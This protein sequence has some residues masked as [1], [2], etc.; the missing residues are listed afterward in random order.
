MEKVAFLNLT[1]N[2]FYHNRIWEEFFNQGDLE[3]KLEMP[4]SATCDR[5]S[6]VVA[7]AQ[8]FFIDLVVRPALK[9]F[10]RLEN[11]CE[12]KCMKNLDVCQDSWYAVAKATRDNGTAAATTGNG[13]SKQSAKKQSSGSSMSN[14]DDED[15]SAECNGGGD[16]GKQRTYMSPTSA[17]LLERATGATSKLSRPADGKKGKRDKPPKKQR[18]RAEAG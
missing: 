2:S 5:S 17:A 15:I 16:K 18:K 13:K 8:V 10:F 6:V 11:A 4:V 12:E 14:D 3:K 7:N 9:I 1:I